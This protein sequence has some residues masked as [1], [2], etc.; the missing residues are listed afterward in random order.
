LLLIQYSTIQ[1]GQ[2]ILISAAETIDSWLLSVRHDSSDVTMMPG[3]TNPAVSSRQRCL[4]RQL[5][6]DGE[7]IRAS[8]AVCDGLL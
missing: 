4:Y 1:F 6:S 7:R 5:P 2:L 8:C 3:R